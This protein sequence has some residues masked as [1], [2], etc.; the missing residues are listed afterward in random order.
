MGE[1]WGRHNFQK[2][3]VAMRN[4]QMLPLDTTITNTESAMNFQHYQVLNLEQTQRLLSRIQ[5]ATYF[6][7]QA[8]ESIGLSPERMG[9]QTSQ[10]TAT[11]VEQSV[12]ASYAQTEMYFVQHSEYLMPRV[13]QM[14]TDLAQ[15]YHSTNPSVRLSYMT[16]LDEKVNFE[17][18]GTKLLLRDLNVFQS[19]KVNQR[20]INDQMKNLAMSNNTA[21]ASIYDL[22]KLIAA[23]SLAEINSVMKGME[24]K[25][26][27][28][29]QEEMKHAESM[30]QMELDAMQ[31]AEEAKQRFEAEQKQL[32]R[33]SE[34]RVAEIR[35]AGFSG[36]KDLDGNMQNDY[37]DNLEY[38]DKRQQ[39]QDNINLKRE[40]E[41]KKDARESQKLS[42]KREEI[43]ARKEIADK[44]V[45]V[46][47]TNK[48]KYD[49]KKSSDK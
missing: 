20:M 4:F 9:Q 36:M 13:H 5:L 43:A 3:Y 28:M 38:L 26:D 34:E 29:R 40:S 10:T 7:Q 30:K 22:G 14:R 37:I 45:E 48:N 17:I 1:D 15:Y 31:Q 47:K 6:K 16:T 24:Q 25:A 42:V 11:G 49:K 39:H 12:Q 21:G 23:D 18:N 32:D 2:A 27:A 33:E 19:T 46:A 41:V 35:S 44:Q 8:F